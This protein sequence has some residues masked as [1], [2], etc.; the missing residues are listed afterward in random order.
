ME[1]NGT[2]SNTS[3]MQIYYDT[4]DKNEVSSKLYKQHGNNLFLN[5][6]QSLNQN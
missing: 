2:L 5:V 3:R 1:K 6:K 4:G